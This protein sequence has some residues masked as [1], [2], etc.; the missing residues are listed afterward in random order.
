[1]S[2]SAIGPHALVLTVVPYG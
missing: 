1:L 2:G